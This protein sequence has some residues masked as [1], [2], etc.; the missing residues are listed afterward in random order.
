MKHWIGID[1]SSATLDFALLDEHGVHLESLQV[2]NGRTAVM[3]LMNS[4]KK[5]Y[6]VDTGNA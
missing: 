6:G 1:V 2:S 4:W 5:R 3:T